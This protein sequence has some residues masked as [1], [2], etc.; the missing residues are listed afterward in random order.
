MKDFSFLCIKS[1]IEQ[2]DTLYGCFE[3]GPFI[4][5]QGITIANSL[6]RE[7][8]SELTGL[9]IT[10]VEI[11]NIS[12]EYSTIQGV[13]ESVLEILLNLKQLVFTTNYRERY[14]KKGFLRFQGPGTV[15]A[16]DLRLP[17]GIR[18]VDPNQYIATVSYNG[19]LNLKFLI[20]YGKGYARQTPSSLQWSL[21]TETIEN[22]EEEA[23][24]ETGSNSMPFV[25]AFPPDIHKVNS[26][27]G[28]QVKPLS[29]IDAKAGESGTKSGL[30]SMQGTHSSSVPFNPDK[31]NPFFV[32]DIHKVNKDTLHSKSSKPNQSVA[33]E[34][35]NE[36]QQRKGANQKVN[37]SETGQNSGEG[38]QEDR[39]ELHTLNEDH[40]SSLLNAC[41]LT[42]DPVFSPVKRVNFLL[43]EY[44]YRD[45]L[46]DK[47]ILEVWTNGSI[48]PRQAVTEAGK[49]LLNLFLPFAK[50]SSFNFL[51]K[52]RVFQK[53]QKSRFKTES[54]LNEKENRLP[55]QIEGQRL[56]SLLN[57][58]VGNLD[59]SIR[60]YTQLKRAKIDTIG[61]LFSQNI[62]TLQSLTTRNAPVYKTPPSHSQSI[63]QTSKPRSSVTRRG[64]DLEMS[65]MIGSADVSQPSEFNSD[66]IS[67]V[68]EPTGTDSRGARN[69]TV[70]DSYTE[71]QV[72]DACLRFGLPIQTPVFL[73]TKKSPT[74][75]KK[76][77]QKSLIDKA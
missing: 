59:L 44:T 61:D 75:S 18:C 48:H 33:F 73:H 14:P 9:A 23:K 42:I 11:E 5:G 19:S 46:A 22:N 71:D 3:F 28:S 35:P 53:V 54:T 15:K 50:R 77:G 6:R 30:Q 29:S 32:A 26:S 13:R 43:Q 39:K 1:R 8:L 72:I 62:I 68:P 41:K 69:K 58:D 17:I 60:T 21:P 76:R 57:L 2:N 27:K 16:G 4:L 38:V 12:H 66:L 25:E 34:I 36:G 67:E 55:V 64:I 24:N 52:E 70:I 63:G 65:Q 31:D 37:R 10:E 49:S 56:K 45:Q 20:C 40:T 74:N 47:V 7:L 51:P